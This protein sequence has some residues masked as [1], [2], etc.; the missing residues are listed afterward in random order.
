VI[1]ARLSDEDWERYQRLLRRYGSGFKPSK[2][3][4]FRKLL[5]KLDF[6]YE[7]L[8][9]NEGWDWDKE[10]PREENPDEQCNHGCLI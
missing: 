7:T 5:E 2:S 3:E 8:M 6:P 9:D 1:C 4:S 10:Q